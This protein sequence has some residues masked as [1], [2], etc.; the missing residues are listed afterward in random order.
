[1]C[2]ICG[3]SNF[4]LDLPVIQGEVKA[5]RGGLIHSG[6]D[7]E[8]IFVHGSL[9]ILRVE[10][11]LCPMRMRRFGSSSTENWFDLYIED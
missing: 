7:D 11:S 10:N 5:M 6:P 9:L 2:G 8:G 3:I 1:M 4:D